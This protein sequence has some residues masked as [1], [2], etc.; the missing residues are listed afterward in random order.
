MRI[1]LEVHV[2]LPT[3]TKLFCS[4]KTYVEEPN[5]SI[6]PICMGMPGSKPKLNRKALMIGLSV[7]AALHCKVKEKIGF[8]RKV[9]FYPDLPKNYQI[10][11]LYDPVG[12]DGYIELSNKRIGIRRVQLEE[13][14]ARVYREGEY[15]L[16]DFNRSGTPLLEIVTEPDIASEEELREFYSELRSILYYFGIEIDREMKADLNISLSKSRVEV[17]N[18][19]G[20]KNLVDAAK[21]EIK[22]QSS[23]L[24]RGEEPQTETR[25]YIPE[26]MATE[27]TREKETDEEYGYIFEPDLTFYSTKMELMKPVYASRIASEYA[28]KYGANEMT[29]KELIAYDRNALELLEAEAGKHGMQDIIAALEQLKRYKITMGPSEFSEVV[30]LVEEKKAIDRSKLSAIAE[31]RKVLSDEKISEGMIAD[32][33]KRFIERN[34]KIVEEIKKNPKSINT[35]VG[36]VSKAIGADPRAVLKL[37]KAILEKN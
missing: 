12:Y 29:L 25:S 20:I 23:I 8:V 32:E 36:S 34:P 35:V 2:A 6:C 33:I 7:S 5:T 17:K 11:Q 22:R 15:T 28:K 4:C 16:L 27:H 24:E 9:Y 13:D 14:P 31:G 18:I 30:K 26:H 19:T 10:T 1:G 37:A 3:E 21:Y